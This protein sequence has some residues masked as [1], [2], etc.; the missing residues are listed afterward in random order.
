VGATVAETV[1]QLDQVAQFLRPTQG[2]VSPGAPHFS[3]RGSTAEVGAEPVETA[4]V[5]LFSAKS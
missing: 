2:Q 5:S 1:S 4:E 3:T